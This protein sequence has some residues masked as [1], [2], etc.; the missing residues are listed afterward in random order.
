MNSR[1]KVGPPTCLKCSHWAM[2]SSAAG[3]LLS[4][5][6][7][8]LAPLGNSK[9]TLTRC[10]GSYCSGSPSRRDV[11]PPPAEPFHYTSKCR[12]YMYSIVSTL[13]PPKKAT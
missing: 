6:R 2:V 3:L 12:A 13:T 9:A 11:W 1:A 10:L 8:S 4:I 5:S 7:G